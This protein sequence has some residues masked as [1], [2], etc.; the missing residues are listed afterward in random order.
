[1]H[2]Q[3][4]G[5]FSNLE[6]TLKKKVLPVLRFW[7]KAKSLHQKFVIFVQG[8]MNQDDVCL[9]RHIVVQSNSFKSKEQ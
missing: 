2:I 4:I 3:K 7:K 8:G 9:D 6:I 5:F 1:M